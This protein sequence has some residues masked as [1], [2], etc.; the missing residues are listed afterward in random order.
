MFVFFVLIKSLLTYLDVYGGLI[1]NYGWAVER[2]I[3]I[4]AVSDIF[5]WKFRPGLRSAGC[6]INFTW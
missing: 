1:G 5:T 6:F 2:R 3:S 4:W